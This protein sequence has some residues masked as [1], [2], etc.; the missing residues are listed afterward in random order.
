M[1]VGNR[2]ESCGVALEFDNRGMSWE[3]LG[4][5]PLA[6]ADLN[7]TLNGPKG[8]IYA[9]RWPEMVFDEGGD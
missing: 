7:K 2:I 6:L 4:N 3:K 1:I 5:C 8:V 9:E